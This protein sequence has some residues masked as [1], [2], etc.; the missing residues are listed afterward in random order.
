MK[1]RYE[2]IQELEKKFYQNLETIET[3][4]QTNANIKKLLI[5]FR[6]M[7]DGEWIE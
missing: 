7:T 2:R 6:Q 5:A 4:R 3:L 1:T